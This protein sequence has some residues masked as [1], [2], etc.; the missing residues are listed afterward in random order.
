MKENKN[1]R[2]QIKKRAIKLV[3][4]L[5]LL[6]C[7]ISFYKI[8]DVNYQ[9]HQEIKDS[10][11]NHPENL[12]KKEVAKITSF[13]FKNFRADLY[14]LQTIQYIWWNVIGSE[15]KKYLYI[16]LDLVTELNPYFEHPY[17]VWELLLPS[18]NERYENLSE[19][20]QQKNIDQSVLLWIKWVNNFC[21]LEKIESIKKESD[22]RKIFTDEKYTNPCKD[23]KIPYYLAY[24]YYFYLHDWKKASDYY[25]VTSANKNSVE[26]AKTMAAIMQGKWW[27]REKS[28]YMFLNLAKSI[29]NEDKGCIE[30]ANY[31][32]SEFYKVTSNKAILDDLLIAKVENLRNQI[33]GWIWEYNDEEFL[34]D[35]RCKSYANKA[36]REMNLY[37]LEN[38]NK[39]YKKDHNWTS[40][41]NAKVLQDD[42]YIKFLPTDFQQYEDYW[43]IYIYN[44]DLGVFDYEM[45]N[46]DE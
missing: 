33:F 17:I 2:E 46:Y 7:I 15:Y 40:A 13:W 34:W 4:I 37:F 1:S 6:F 36:V 18:Y 19:E 25:K 30:F 3:K 5:L 32:E 22:L 14:R 23:Y 43:I 44:K 11:V 20:E 9:K 27:D 41:M 38:A 45:G 39:E 31:L 8:N 21:D 28:I 24:I 12:P 35:T 29:E 42:W 16:I 10:I 26:W